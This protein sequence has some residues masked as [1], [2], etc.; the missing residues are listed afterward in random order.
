M[1]APSQ[2]R[3]V[4]LDWYVWEVV[5]DDGSGLH[6]P[7][8]GGLVQHSVLHSCKLQ[9]LQ[10]LPCQVGLLSTQVAEITLGVSFAL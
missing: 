10:T 3:G 8:H 2:R 7:S 5:L 4:C 6:G 1:G 9:L